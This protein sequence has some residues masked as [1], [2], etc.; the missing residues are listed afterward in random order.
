MGFNSAFE[1]LSVPQYI[2]WVLVK[3]GG[4]AR[5]QCNISIFYLISIY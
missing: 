4:D 2:E 5:I 3:N 1:G